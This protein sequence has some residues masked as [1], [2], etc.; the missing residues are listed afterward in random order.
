MLIKSHTPSH[1]EGEP[2]GWLC[3]EPLTLCPIDTTPVLWDLMLPDE[4]AYLN[5]YHAR[6]REALLPLLDDEADR[7]WLIA[8]TEAR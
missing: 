1:N 6:V 2:D 8:H 5:G 4:I 7:A 3:L